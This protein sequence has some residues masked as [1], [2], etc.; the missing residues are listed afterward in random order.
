[1]SLNNKTNEITGLFIILYI[2]LLYNY[3]TLYK[4]RVPNDPKSFL[5]NIKLLVN[6]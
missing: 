6:T 1:M 3:I 4:F 5:Q 2:I